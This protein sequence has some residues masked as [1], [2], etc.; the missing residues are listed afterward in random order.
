[1]QEVGDAWLDAGIVPFSTLGWQ[2]PEWIEHG[3][4]TGA[5]AGLTGADLPDHAYWEKWFPADWVSEMREQIRLWFYSQSL[6]VGDPHRDVRRTGRVLTYEKLLDENGREMHRSWGNAI[7]AAEALENMGADVIRFMFCEQ[8]PSQNLKFGY[9]PAGEIKRR[10][11]TLWNSVK[12]F[13]DY[14]NI[15][16][17]EPRRRG[18]AEP[19]AAR[20]LA[21]R[22]HRAARRRDDGG[23]RALLDAGAHPR[24]RVVRR[25][26]LELVHPPLA[27]AL[28]GRRR[29][30]VVDAL[31]CARAL[32]ADDR[33]RDAV[34]GRLP[35]AHVARRRRTRVGLPRALARGASNGRGPARRGRRGASQSSSSGARLAATRD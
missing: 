6:H 4:A 27:P 8:V 24:V 5:A 17:F 1:M 29:G 19:P 32:G 26:P 13:V 23:V 14:A 16:G 15:E 21:A 12:F 34:P 7:D 35:L 9:G 30:C 11:L 3:Y 33:A 22:A 31:A 2:N 10:L 18:P 20:P 28:L 25:R